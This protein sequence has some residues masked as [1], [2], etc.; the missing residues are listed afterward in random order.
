MDSVMKVLAKQQNLPKM[1]YYQTCQHEQFQD[2]R[3]LLCGM[4]T[5]SCVCVGKSSFC[6]KSCNCHPDCPN[7]FP[8]CRCK[9]PCTNKSQCLCLMAAREC[10]PDLCKN[11]CTTTGSV[12]TERNSLPISHELK[13]DEDVISALEKDDTEDKLI[14]REYLRRNGMRQCENNY[15]QRPF[16]SSKIVVGKF[17]VN[18]FIQFRNFSVP[19]FM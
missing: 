6:D 7:R 5:E 12:F 19:K 3:P 4:T 18:N 14:R 8:G 17:R 10:D 13:H 16:D 2:G 9:G 15:M 1:P 11:C